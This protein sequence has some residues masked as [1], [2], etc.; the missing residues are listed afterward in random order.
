MT[1]TQDTSVSYGLVG[2]IIEASGD[3]LLKRSG[4]SD[5]QLTSVGTE[6]YPGD[7]LHPTRGARVLVQ[8]ANGTTI[9]SVPDGVISG[10][11]NGCPPQ[12]IPVSRHRGDIIPPRGGINP[13]I[14]YI[15]SPRRTLVLNPLPTLCWNPV[16]GASCYSVNLIG[17]EEVLWERQVRE[18]EI[19]YSGEPPLESGVDYLL[20]IQ[21]DTGVS[22]EE[23]DLPDLGFNLLDENKIT[24]VR[25]TVDQLVN[26]DLTD[27][28]KSLAL[29]HVYIKYELRAEAIAIL[30]AL[31][32]LGSKTAAVYRTIGELYTEVGLNL[33]ARKYYLKAIELTG[34][35]DIEGQA[36]VAAGLGKVYEAIASPQDAI[37]WL[38][39]AR[40]SYATL[41]DTQQAL[42]LAQ[43]LTRL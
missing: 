5:Y 23:E 43:K 17:D 30:E 39:Q 7:I 29:V 10:A 28:A 18:A 35:E 3:V 13:L 22:S 15:I 41:G 24:L 14:P 19:V 1:S 40:D 42:A 27:E 37:G 34:S 11:T 9:W 12:T 6:L 20:I 2:W 8:C 4:W 31:V 26:L 32:K 36:L 33:L 21:A 25:D 38:T 16:P